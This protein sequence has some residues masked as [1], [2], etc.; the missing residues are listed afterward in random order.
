MVSMR[1]LLP[2]VSGTVGAAGA[3][4]IL[5]T[6]QSPVGWMKLSDSY[7]APGAALLIGGIS[8]FVAHLGLE[9]V[10]DKRSAA[11][12]GETRQN[13]SRVYGELLGHIIESFTLKPKTLSEA[14][15]RSRAV[16][17]ASPA[18]YAA[19][20]DWFRYAAAQSSVS[21]KPDADSLLVRRELVYRVAAAMRSDLQ[22]EDISREMLLALVFNDFDPETVFPEAV[23]RGRVNSNGEFA[24]ALLGSSEKEPP[25]SALHNPG[26]SRGLNPPVSSRQ[27]AM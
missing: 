20:T 2:Y 27:R 7:I 13:R 21:T 14:Q 18:T 19:L 26:C 15:A 3:V 10:T 4:M 9:T 25:F 1:A 24:P 6:V 5:G 22:T 11:V 16:A 23:M 12:A 17:W 8:S